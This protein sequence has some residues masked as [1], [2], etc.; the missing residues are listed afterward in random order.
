VILLR[1]KCR[2][3]RPIFVITKIRLTTKPR[4]FIVSPHLLNQHSALAIFRNLFYAHRFLHKQNMFPSSVIPCVSTYIH[5]NSEKFPEFA[6]I[7][8]RNW[9]VQFTV[10]AGVK[11]KHVYVFRC[12]GM[13][14]EENAPKNGEPT[15]GVSYTKLLH[16]TGRFWSRIS[17][18]RT[19]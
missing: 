15:A 10:F 1:Q 8:F 2:F 5:S 17:L 19:V 16:Y 11:K 3:S 14:S 12:L 7:I 4:Y 6:G 18:E 13:C 9:Q